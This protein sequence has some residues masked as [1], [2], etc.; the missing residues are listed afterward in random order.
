[1]DLSKLTKKQKKKLNNALLLPWIPFYFITVDS[2]FSELS[3]VTISGAGAP[4]SAVPGYRYIGLSQLVLAVLQFA[5]MMYWYRPIGRFV[6]TLD[7]E[8]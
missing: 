7:P 5:M 4:L 6:K 8:L 2:V 1:M 3:L